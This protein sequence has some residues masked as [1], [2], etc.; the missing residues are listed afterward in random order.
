MY[1]VKINTPYYIPH[2]TGVKIT[3]T[4]YYLLALPDHSRPLKIY[5]KNIYIQ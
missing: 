4:E 2:A 1:L 5:Q 3:N